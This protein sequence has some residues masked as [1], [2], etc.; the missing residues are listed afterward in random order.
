MNPSNLSNKDLEEL[1]DKFSETWEIDPKVREIRRIP[2]KA[3]DS[4]YPVQVVLRYAKQ[5]QRRNLGRYPFP[6]ATGNNIARGLYILDNGWNIPIED[7]KYL[8]NGPLYAEDRSTVIVSEEDQPTVN[9]HERDIHW[10]ERAWVKIL[11]VILTF[12]GAA[13]AISQFWAMI[14]PQLAS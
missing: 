9:A 6:F 4:Q 2:S 8:T 12:L 11:M 3:D 5:N 7:R 10:Y 14:M 1:T 13:V